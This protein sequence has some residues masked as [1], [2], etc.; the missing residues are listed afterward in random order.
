M[1]DGPKKKKREK[2]RSHAAGRPLLPVK[3]HGFM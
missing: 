3:K 2:K 1:K